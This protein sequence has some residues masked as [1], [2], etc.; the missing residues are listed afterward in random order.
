METISL[1]EFQRHGAEYVDRLPVVLTRY[2]EP[3]AKVVEIQEGLGVST[4]S[5]EKGVGE[6]N[7]STE[8]TNKG[9]NV[10]TG[11]D[12]E[13]ER[14][15]TCRRVKE[16]APVKAEYPNGDVRELKICQKCFDK[17]LDGGLDIEWTY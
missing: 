9:R 10:S 16:I 13:V 15:E 12:F 1:R 17:A 5:E 3:I 14:C 4:K 11:P 6:E 2:G 8:E 7:V